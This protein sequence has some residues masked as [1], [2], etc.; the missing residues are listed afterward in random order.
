MQLFQLSEPPAFCHE[1]ILLHLVQHPEAEDARGRYSRR[2]SAV[3]GSETEVVD[4]G[5]PRSDFLSEDIE[6]GRRDH[7]DRRIDVHNDL[8]RRS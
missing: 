7:I 1:G 8:I 2:E 3:H 6:G 4:V 5:V